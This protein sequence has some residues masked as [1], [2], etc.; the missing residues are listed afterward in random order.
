M[1]CAFDGRAAP[2]LARKCDAS[3]GMVECRRAQAA[4]VNARSTA[5]WSEGKVLERRYGSRDA[6][7]THCT[8]TN[9]CAVTALRRRRQRRERR[10]MIGMKRRSDCMPQRSV[11]EQPALP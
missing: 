8:A 4:R 11:K 9:A 2:C 1:Q 10:V 3:Q 5:V 7:P 6:A